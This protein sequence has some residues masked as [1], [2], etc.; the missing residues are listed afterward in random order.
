MRVKA[1]RREL[2]PDLDDVLASALLRGD[3]ITEA[4]ARGVPALYAGVSFIA[5]MVSTLP[6]RLYSEA[7]GKTKPLT[8]PRTALINDDTGDL[9]D[10]VQLKAAL[11]TDYLLNGGATRLKAY[12]T[13]S[14]LRSAIKKM[15]TRFLRPQPTISAGGKLRAST[16]SAC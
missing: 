12:I 4:T 7:D 15:P 2:S 9:L 1:E 6:V 13:S 16:L 14:N 10:G 8:D 3:R 5:G 11:V